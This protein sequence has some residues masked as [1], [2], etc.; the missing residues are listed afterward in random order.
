MAKNKNLRTCLVTGKK[1]MPENLQR[2]IIKDGALCFD[3]GKKQPGRG[4][5]LLPTEENLQK[6]PK[7]TK[8]INYFL[9]HEGSI[10]MPD[11]ITIN[12]DN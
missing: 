1:L 4:G 12:L 3:Q 9:Q 10:K 6:L 2:F 5:Y 7:L 8:K 11:K